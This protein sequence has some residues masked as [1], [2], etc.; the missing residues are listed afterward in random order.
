MKFKPSDPVSLLPKV[1]PVYTK[2]LEKLEIFTIKDLL[3]HFPYRYDDYSQQKE[4]IDLKE[5]DTVTVKGEIKS[6]TNILTPTSKK[7]TVAKIFDG[8]TLDITWFNQFF[9]TTSF[10][11][12]DL[13]VATGKVMLF[14]NKLSM[15]SPDIEHQKEEESLNSGRLVPVY[16]E[17][18][19]ITSKFLRNH[20][21]QTLQNTNLDELE[22]LP[23]EITKRFDFDKTHQAL[24]KIH[25][26]EN[27]ED[28]EKASKQ[29]AFE[30][31]FIYML[32]LTKLK[33]EQNLKTARNT[34]DKATTLISDFIK[35]LPFEPPLHL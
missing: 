6:I 8:N 19:G 34:Y 28:I 33:Q 4:I 22:L 18:M 9:L 31:A 10:K 1:G 7:I 35:L 17:T 29:F 12:D 13:I 5:G 2:L 16:P 24:K 15:M 11:K 30:E 3:Y 20:I 27:K 23:H 26:P 32:R 14:K 25:F 21:F